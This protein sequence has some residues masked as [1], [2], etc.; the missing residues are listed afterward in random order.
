M[1]AKTW[2]LIFAAAAIAAGACVLFLTQ[3]T[4]VTVYNPA[5]SGPEFTIVIL[6]SSPGG[7][8]GRVG[9]LRP[10]V[11]ARAV[12]RDEAG[13]WLLLEDPRGWVGAHLVEIRGNVD[14]LP[15]T[16]EAV[17]VA[18]PVPGSPVTVTNPEMAAGNFTVNVLALPKPGADIVGTLNPGDSASAI[19]RDSAGAW[20]LLAEPHGWALGPIL[21][22]TGDV[23]ALPVTTGGATGEPVNPPPNAE[24]VQTQ[25]ASAFQAP[26]A[27][28]D[29]WQTAAPS[30]VG[31]VSQPLADMVGLLDSTPAHGYHSVAIVKDGKLVFERYF[32]GQDLDLAAYTYALTPEKTFGPETPH[33]LASAAK[34]VTSLLVGI[35][36]D[37]GLI[38]SASAKVFDSFPEYAD[39]ATGT[40]TDITI[41]D[42]L[43]MTTGLPWD[44]SPAYTDPA[45]DLARM[46]ASSD[47][48]RVVLEM[49]PGAAPGKAWI[50]NS[51]TTNVLGE[52][53]RRAAGEPLAQFA[54]EALFK[55]LGIASHSWVG[56]AADPD[57]AFASSALYLTP[58]DMAKIGQLCL[59]GGTWNGRRI[60]SADWIAASTQESVALP[61]AMRAP[62][63]ATGYGYQW[64]IESYRGGTLDAYSARG[65]GGQYIVVIPSAKLVVVFTGGLW[66]SSPLAAPI[67]Y[68]DLIENYVLRSALGPVN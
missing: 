64:W 46:C 49:T 43:T 55:P 27:D 41:R 39:L 2:I 5:A 29:G 23:N 45:N 44:E 11:R 7:E 60:V 53:V 58:R 37:K 51:G 13:A 30:D 34:S 62:Y 59:N 42:A 3:P 68:Y 18:A 6:R 32:S 22:V 35:A 63:H 15:I 9:S 57:M 31:M 65:F 33:C 61:A 4:R 36:I 40:K 16:N 52:I 25:S 50:Y 47:P 54:A 48:L 38:Q 26:P 17:A 12:G 10:G 14:S 28:D 67:M 66:S 20:L 19:G 24:P 1:T 8:Y 21:E 56:F